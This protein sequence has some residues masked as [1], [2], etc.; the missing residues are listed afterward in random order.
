MLL[1]SANKVAWAYQMDHVRMTY[2][3]RA[4]ICIPNCRLE[5]G[6]PIGLWVDD[7]A[8]A[9]EQFG[10]EKHRWPVMSSTSAK[11]VFALAFEIVEDRSVLVG[12]NERIEP[13]IHTNVA[14]FNQVREPFELMIEFGE[15]LDFSGVIFKVDGLA[16]VPAGN[17]AFRQNLPIEIGIGNGFLA[18]MQDRVEKGRLA[19]RSD[20]AQKLRLASAINVVAYRAIDQADV[21]RDGVMRFET[22][23]YPVSG[24]VELVVPPAD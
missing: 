23:G 10:V 14:L 18:I 16:E 21:D 11:L 1:Q 7:D 4:Q 6:A 22:I 9:I 19:I 20:V 13:A 2:D 5:E 24:L 8:I 12:S 17:C 3:E 15:R